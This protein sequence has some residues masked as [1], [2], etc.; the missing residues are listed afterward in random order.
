MGLKLGSL[1]SEGHFT[2]VLFVGPI[3]PHI[4]YFE[5][6][7]GRVRRLACVLEPPLGLIQAWAV[8]V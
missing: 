6:A 7:A 5:Q 2:L 8:H 4:D 1:F 3:I